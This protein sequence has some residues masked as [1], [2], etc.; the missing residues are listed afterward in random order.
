MLHCPT[1]GFRIEL[2]K[3][4]SYLLT[5]EQ[6]S[7]KD[8]IFFLKTSIFHSLYKSN[9]KSIIE[10]KGLYIRRYSKAR[11]ILRVVNIQC[12]YPAR[13]PADSTNYI[14]IFRREKRPAITH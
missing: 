8:S 6:F 14:V 9:N 10:I 13:N 11:R 1:R 5:I 3:H 4:L 2:N 7:W 12:S